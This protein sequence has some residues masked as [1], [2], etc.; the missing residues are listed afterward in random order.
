MLS[1]KNHGVWLAWCRITKP[2]ET[3]SGGYIPV[4]A[5][6]QVVRNIGQFL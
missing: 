4:L 1:C 5:E 2:T 6:S 3:H